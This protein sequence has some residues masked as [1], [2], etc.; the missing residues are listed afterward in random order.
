M[1]SKNALSSVLPVRNEGQE[2]NPVIAENK[3]IEIPLTNHAN[4]IVQAVKKRQESFLP[5]F[6]RKCF[7]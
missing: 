3:H 2:I 4:L 6:Y 7:Y 1:I 5:S